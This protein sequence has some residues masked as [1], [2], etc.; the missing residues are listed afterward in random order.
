MATASIAYDYDYLVGVVLGAGTRTFSVC[1]SWCVCVFVLVATGTEPSVFF[2]VTVSLSVLGKIF[3][4]SF[5]CCTLLGDMHTRGRL[6]MSKFDLDAP[7]TRD[8]WR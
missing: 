8:T 1:F 2:C 7:A 5:L 6:S 3:D 4:F